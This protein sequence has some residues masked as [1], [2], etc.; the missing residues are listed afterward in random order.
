MTAASPP[1]APSTPAAISTAPKGPVPSIIQARRPH[2]YSR[3]PAS[4]LP[5][6][7]AAAK[8]GARD[9]HAETDDRCGSVSLPGPV[10]ASC[11][12]RQPASS[13]GSP[14]RRMCD[15]HAGP[16]PEQDQRRPRRAG[17]PGAPGRERVIR[18]LPC[19]YPDGETFY[20][21]QNP[22]REPSIFPDEFDANAGSPEGTRAVPD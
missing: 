13:C 12:R 19:A 17:R 8:T 10:Y 21:G 22:S 3:H 5:E 20:R 4:S 9:R 18:P 7:A 6:H 15:D 2:H 14:V 1:T 11:Q 16:R